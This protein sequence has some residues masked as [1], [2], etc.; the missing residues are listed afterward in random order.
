MARKIDLENH[1][2]KLVRTL[3]FN[4]SPLQEWIQRLLLKNVARS[5]VALCDSLDFV[6][7]SH[8]T[9]VTRRSLDLKKRDNN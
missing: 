3:A 5:T 4:S 8:G 6:L 2:N 1:V 9:R 7:L